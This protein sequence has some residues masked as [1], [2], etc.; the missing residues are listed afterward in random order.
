MAIRIPDP[1]IKIPESDIYK[2]SGLQWHSLRCEVVTPMYGGGVEAATIDTKMPIRVSAIRGQLRFWW[3]L[4]AKNKWK[5]GNTKAIR[6]AEFALWGGMGDD[7]GGRASQVFLKVHQQ[8][9]ITAHDLISYVEYS[10]IKNE[11]KLSYVLFPAANAQDKE[12]NPHQLLKIDKIHFRLDVAF[13]ATVQHDQKLIDQIIETLQ[14][15]SNFGGLGARNRRGMGAVHVSACEDFA[16]IC[17]PLSVDDVAEA[18]C[19]LALKGKSP[20]AIQQLQNGIAKLSE[21]R[22]KA[23]VGRNKGTAPKPAG[24]SRWPEPDALR[25]VHRTHHVNHAP[26]HEAGNIFPRAMFGLPIIFHF[27]G[28]GEPRDSQL[29]PVNGDRLASPVIIRPY[30]TGTVNKDGKKE[31]SAAALVLPHE[32]IKKM[33]VTIGGRETY[34]IWTADSAAKIRPI[35]D[36]QGVDPLAAFLHYFAN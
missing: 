33:Q 35:N 7:S 31:W 10:G 14:W 9:K 34:P 27:V 32:H 15:W 36:H 21:F 17:Q 16:Q 18:G 12:V 23:E 24:R 11:K 1:S 13:S 2:Q 29:S 20:D 5:L 3:R 6:D 4:L 8:P 25:R 22:Q 19:T 28:A 26:E 30:H